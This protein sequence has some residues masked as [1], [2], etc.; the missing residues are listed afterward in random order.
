MS[1]T[2]VHIFQI[3]Y[4]DQ[5]RNI[6][7]P[8]FLPLDNRSN[9][10]PD[11]REYWPIRR[12]LSSAELREGDFYGFFSPRFKEK[13]GLSSDDVRRYIDADY[14]VISFSHFFD[15]SCAFANPFE[16]GEAHHAGF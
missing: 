15:Q 4:S 6:L 1:E 5:T 12:F 9:E 10:R 16:Q 7:D 13:T 8:G 2:K 14:D 3:Y 11:W